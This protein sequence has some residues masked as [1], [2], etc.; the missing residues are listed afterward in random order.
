MKFEELGLMV[1]GAMQLQIGDS[2]EQRYPVRFYGIN[3]KGSVIV[4]APH[5]SG[6]KMIFIREGQMVNLRFMVKNVA[7]G[8]SS[9]VIAT[10]GQPYPYVHLEIPKEIQTVE[11]R[12]DVR[13]STNFKVTVMNKTHNS[14]ALV[15]KVINLSCSGGRLE[16]GNNIAHVGNKLNIT[17]KVDIDDIARMLT[18]DA[19]VI[20]V[21]PKK[22]GD[23]YNYGFNINSIDEEDQ[24]AL[25][26]FVYQELLRNLYML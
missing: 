18:F 10:R 12:K 13:V 24:I 11:V 21:K 4:S 22:E 14:S 7:S 1:G 23:G 3:P 19:D 8:F 5:S 16:S 6:D 20:N 17:F 2:G 15:G 25:H 9:R 26:A